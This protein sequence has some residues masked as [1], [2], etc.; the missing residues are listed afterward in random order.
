MCVHDWRATTWIRKSQQ[1][2][3]RTKISHSNT[4]RGQVVLLK[5]V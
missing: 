4:Q 1:N 2:Q 5:R 3:W